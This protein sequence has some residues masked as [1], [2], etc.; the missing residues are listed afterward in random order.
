MGKDRIS[1]IKPNDKISKLSY[2]SQANNEDERKHLIKTFNKEKEALMK[3]MNEDVI[4][5]PLLPNSEIDLTE[6]KESS[7]NSTA[8]N[9]YLNE[10]NKRY[11]VPNAWNYATDENSGS[12]NNQSA[13]IKKHNLSN[14][15]P[16]SNRKNYQGL[17]TSAIAK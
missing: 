2:S 15:I 12:E 9:N 3:S 11:K 1:N 4:S 14:N 16:K 6:P 17:Y 8:K 5:K 10:I 13:K 7:K